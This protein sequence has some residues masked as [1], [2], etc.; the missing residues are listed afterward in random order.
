MIYESP[1]IL[2]P[3]PIEAQPPILASSQ[4]APAPPPSPEQI[5]A[6]EAIFAARERESQQVA[7]LLGLWTSAMILNDLAAET[8]SHPTGAEEEAEKPKPK[9]N[10]ED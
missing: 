9:L 8:F 1:P 5:R 10:K 3:A 4:E 7:N 6:A 2:T